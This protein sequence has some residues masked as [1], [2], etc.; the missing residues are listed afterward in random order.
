MAACT[1]THTCEAAASWAMQDSGDEGWV[2]HMP[3]FMNVGP[4]KGWSSERDIPEP[5]AKSFRQ[6]WRERRKAK[7]EQ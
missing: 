1:P 3:W 6:L 5:A 7:A 2:R 4:V